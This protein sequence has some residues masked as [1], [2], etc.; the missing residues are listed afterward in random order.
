M[1]MTM[2]YGMGCKLIFPP[3]GPCPPPL[4]PIL[5]LFSAH[6]VH[7]Q[8]LHVITV[9]NTCFHIDPQLVSRSTCKCAGK[10]MSIPTH[11]YKYVC[12][13]ECS[14]SPLSPSQMIAESVKKA[15]IFFWRFWRDWWY[16]LLVS[17]NKQNIH[18]ISSIK[19]EP[20][21]WNWK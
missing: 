4:L 2:G 7:T 17:G 16:G 19:A 3:S 5:S 11:T 8:L 21:D 14:C 12:V 20:E 6:S 13:W 18:L 1:T 15:I 9:F 10:C